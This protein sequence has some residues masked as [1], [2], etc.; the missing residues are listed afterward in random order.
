[1]TANSNGMFGRHRALHIDNSDRRILGMA[2][3]SLTK[4]LTTTKTVIRNICLPIIGQTCLK[5]SKSVV[6][7]IRFDSR[8]SI[9]YFCG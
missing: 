4:E 1:M 3:D 9:E 2:V 7:D 5:N 8:W 6:R